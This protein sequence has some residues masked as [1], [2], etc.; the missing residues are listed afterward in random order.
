VASCLPETRAKE[1][2]AVVSL[3]CATED[4]GRALVL[5]TGASRLTLFLSLKFD[6]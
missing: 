6:C 5:V 3:L 2:D 4:F 1:N